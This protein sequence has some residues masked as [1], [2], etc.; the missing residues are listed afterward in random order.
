MNVFGVGWLYNGNSYSSNI[1]VSTVKNFMYTVED[2]V[3]GGNIFAPY[4]IP[5]GVSTLQKIDIKPGTDQDFVHFYPAGTIEVLKVNIGEVTII[6]AQPQQTG[7]PNMDFI[8]DI[9]HDAL[10]MLTDVIPETIKGTITDILPN[11]GPPLIKATQNI[12]NTYPVSLITRGV[13]MALDMAKEYTKQ[14]L[15]KPASGG[16][17]IVRSKVKIISPG[18]SAPST[19]SGGGGGGSIPPISNY[20]QTQ[21]FINQ[22]LSNSSSPA[23]QRLKDVAGR[24]AQLIANDVQGQIR[25]N[26][27]DYNFYLPKS[28]LNQTDKSDF[29]LAIEDKLNDLLQDS[30]KRRAEGARTN[31]N[32][33][34]VS[35]FDD[36]LKKL[37]S[38][39]DLKEILKSGGLKKEDLESLFYASETIGNRTKEGKLSIVEALR[40]KVR[41]IDNFDFGD[42]EL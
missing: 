38:K 22:S 15:T 1:S 20:N 9:A 17:L 42:G 2:E 7:T 13:A 4:G 16:D 25:Q 3:G 18:S 21:T 11:I 35:K 31:E 14:P 12:A 40:D 33:E 5:Y 39:D 41:T 10:N 29:E 26:S 32:I 30:I 24:A 23:V 6:P 34:I 27:D 19:S 37:P 28:E 36:I 8:R